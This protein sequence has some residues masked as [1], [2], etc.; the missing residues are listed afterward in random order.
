MPSLS[1]SC[2][3]TRRLG[4]C[5][6]LSNIAHEDPPAIVEVEGVAGVSVV[7][8]SPVESKRHANL[9]DAMAR[10]FHGHTCKMALHTNTSPHRHAH[11]K[12]PQSVCPMVFQPYRPLR[13][14]PHGIPVHTV[15]PHGISGS[16]RLEISISPHGMPHGVPVHMSMSVSMPHGI[17]VHTAMPSTESCPTVYQSAWYAPWCFSQSAA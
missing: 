16:L 13:Y 7:L 4:A 10:R 1:S 12:K 3:R 2:E 15:C 17:P 6:N 11:G 8:W 5:R 9:H 14:W